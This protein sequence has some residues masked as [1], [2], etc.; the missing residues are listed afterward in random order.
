MPGSTTLYGD[1][2]GL[3]SIGGLGSIGSAGGMT[4]SGPYNDGGRDAPSAK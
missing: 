4:A 3:P 1:V 2:G